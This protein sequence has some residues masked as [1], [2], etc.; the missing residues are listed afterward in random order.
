MYKVKFILFFLA[1]VSYWEIIWLAPSRFLGC[2]FLLPYYIFIATPIIFLLLKAGKWARVKL[3][4]LVLA[5]IILI[6]PAFWFV[7]VLGNCIQPTFF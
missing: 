5:F 4:S 7:R 3:S 6:P 1:V 2:N